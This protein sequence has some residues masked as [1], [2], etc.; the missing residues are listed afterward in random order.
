MRLTHP[1][2]TLPATPEC[3]TETAARLLDFH[4]ATFGTA[5]MDANDGGDGSDGGNEDG[6]DGGDKGG[7]DFKSEQSKEAVLAD[8]K[9]ERDRRKKAEADLADAQA[10]IK[11]HEDAQLSET[12]KLTKERDDL[13]S[14]D[15]DKSLTIARYEAAEEAGLPLSWA[16]R[17]VGETKDAL[18]TDAKAMKADLDSR[19]KGGTPR[20]DP[21][22]GGGRGGTA[23]AGSV[24]EVMEERAAARAAKASQSN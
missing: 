13:R 20:P 9:G 10:K 3:A 2:L 16:R 23:R 4:R 14:S 11:E 24:A 6:S 19:S 8:L 18:L 12:E 21:S 15:S 5:R 22:Q 7:K 1:I 17:L